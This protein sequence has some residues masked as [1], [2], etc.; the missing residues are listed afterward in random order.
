MIHNFHQFFY[1]FKSVTKNVRSE[2][3]MVLILQA[4]ILFFAAYK[5]EYQ[6]ARAYKNFGHVLIMLC[7]QKE[8]QKGIDKIVLLV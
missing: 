3:I 2:N 1:V 5:H 4:P 6:R 8:R 7:K